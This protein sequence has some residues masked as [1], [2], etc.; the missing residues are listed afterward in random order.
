MTQTCTRLGRVLI[1]IKDCDTCGEFIVTYE[2]GGMRIVVKCVIIV[3]NRV[4]IVV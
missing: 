4:I 3:M 2:R 1:V